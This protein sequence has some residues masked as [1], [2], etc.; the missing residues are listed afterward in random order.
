MLVTKNGS[1]DPINENRS[2]LQ[3]CFDRD[4]RKSFFITSINIPPYYP[5]APN[6]IPDGKFPN[7]LILD[8]I[9]GGIQKRSEI[10]TRQGLPQLSFSN[11]F[12]QNT[13]TFFPYGDLIIAEPPPGSI[14]GPSI[15]GKF[16]VRVMACWIWGWGWMLLMSLSG[17]GMAE[18]ESSSSTPYGYVLLAVVGM[19]FALL[20]F[21]VIIVIMYIVLYFYNQLSMRYLDE[22]RDR[23]GGPPPHQRPKAW[24]PRPY[25]KLRVMEEEEEE[26]EDEE[27]QHSDTQQS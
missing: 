5:L 26:D 11:F 14:F 9:Q 4:Q 24:S 13:L 18:G 25:S 15:S 21:A 2:P 6:S 10:P 19:I 1:V 16:V 20:I 22:I 23:R 17:M 8:T 7:C 3:A 27:D 12:Y